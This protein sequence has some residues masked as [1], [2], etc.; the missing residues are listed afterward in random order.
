M[1]KKF[2]ITGVCYEHIHYMMDVSQKMREVMEMVYGGDY[3]I[4]NRPRQYGK[5]TT[6]F[7]IEKTLKLSDDYIVIR[8]NFQG[9]D[10]KWHESDK[11]F[12]KMFRPVQL[13]KR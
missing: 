5:T 8:L 9:I 3:F 2:N 6:L 12:A 11:N 7:L 4:I 13:K 1:K 10:E